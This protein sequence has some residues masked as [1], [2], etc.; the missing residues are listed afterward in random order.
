MS[1]PTDAASLAG[2]RTVARML[3]C[4]S[5]RT[6]S[7]TLE[8]SARLW[9]KQGL[10]KGVAIGSNGI[11]LTI[12]AFNVWYGSRLV[13]Y[14]G[15]QGG[16]VFAVSAAIVVGGLALESGLSNVKYFSEASSAAERVQEVIQRVPKIVSESSAGDELAYVAGEVEFKNV[17]FCYPSRPET[18]IFAS[19]NLPVPVGCTVAL[20]DGSGFGKSTVIALLKR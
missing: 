6:I 17:E 11:I 20:V 8:E 16:T 3:C 9:I 1:E 10:A 19:F 15:Y 4:S 7:A 14:H 18:P 12:W 13:M 2:T 5:S